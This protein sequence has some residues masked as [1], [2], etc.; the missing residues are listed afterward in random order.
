MN[1]DY[2]MSGGDWGWMLAMMVF[3]I[4]AFGVAAWALV[5]FVRRRQTSGRS[6][7]SS[8]LEELDRRLACGELSADEYKRRRDLIGPS[9][10]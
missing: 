8:P 6:R 3:W 9:A 1:G 10:R 7:C 4:A 5:A 2:G